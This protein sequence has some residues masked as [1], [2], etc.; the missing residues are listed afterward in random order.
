MRTAQRGSRSRFLNFMR[1]SVMEMP[2]PPSRG[3]TVTMLICGMPFFLNVVSTPWLGVIVDE[4]LD[5]GGQLLNERHGETPVR[6]VSPGCGG[7]QTVSKRYCSEAR[8][9]R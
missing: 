3:Y 8:R 6:K 2:T 1:V 4:L 9:A 5:L 7:G